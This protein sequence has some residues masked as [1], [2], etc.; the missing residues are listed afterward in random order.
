MSYATKLETATRPPLRLLP[1]D[2]QEQVYDE[3][4]ALAKLLDTPAAAGDRPLRAEQHE[5]YLVHDATRLVVYLRLEARPAD[6]LLTVELL[7]IG[8]Y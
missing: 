6:R 8:G 2:L 7:A 3:L 1:I 4:D 5:L